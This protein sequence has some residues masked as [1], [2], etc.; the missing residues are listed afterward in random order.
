[1]QNIKD[2]LHITADI[3]ENG[4]APASTKMSRVSSTWSKGKVKMKKNITEDIRAKME[5]CP[6]YPDYPTAWAIQKDRG[7]ELE[8]NERCSSIEGWDPMSGP[9]FL[10]DCGAVEREWNRLRETLDK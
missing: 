7:E 2:R 1:M 8:H 10:C 4:I 6:D 9:H 3:A 5:R